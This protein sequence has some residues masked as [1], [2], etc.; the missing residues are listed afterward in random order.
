ML[1]DTQSV[2]L[3]CEV[4]PEESRILRGS[5]RPIVLLNKHPQAT[6]AA[7]L[8]DGLT[9]LGV[10]L[11]YTPVQMLLLHD[12][13][14]AWDARSGA[15]KF[16]KNPPMLVMTSGNIHDEPIVIDDKIAL[17]K[18]GEIAD[19]ILGNNREILTRF[20]DSV[21]RV[22]SVD[23]NTKAVQTIRRA[24]GF[25]PRPLEL[26]GVSS[27]HA[28]LATGPEQK[29]TFTLLNGKNA[30]VSQHI[31]D[32]EN[33]ETFD[34]WLETKARFEQLFA[35]KPTVLACDMHPEYITSKWAHTQSEKQ[36]LPLVEVQ[37]HHAHIVSAMAE[38]NLSDAV[39]GIA[40]DGTGYGV[41]G[42][43]WGGEVLLA[44]RQAF[45]R[46]ANFA[47]IP[48]PGGA[49]CVKHPLRMAYGALWA[50]D[51][52]EHPGAAGVIEALG[53]QQ[54]QVC[55]AMIEQGL[56][57][58]QTSSVG[59]LFD[60]ASA[61]LGVCTEPTYEGEGACKLGALAWEQ[62]ASTGKHACG[63]VECPSTNAGNVDNNAESGASANTNNSA[64]ADTASRYAIQVVKNTAT[65][66]ST[67]QDTS[68]LL[69]DAQPTFKAILDD[70]CAGKS[71]A[72]IALAFHEAIVGA[73]VQAAE[74][75]RALYGL[76]TVVL[77]GGVFMNRLIVERSVF[78]LE[79]RGFTVALNRELPPNDGCISLGQAVIACEKL[80]AAND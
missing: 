79:S 47:Y 71:A 7:G 64:P 66:T 77:S 25:A 21:V 15:G 53:A 37:H 65:A 22:I 58:P 69:F 49:A 23:E 40:F 4:S 36:E 51:L 9:E 57:T 38:N 43:I 29:N 24:R 68:V 44:N 63:S 35:V 28:I 17:G 72:E 19:G 62:Y 80:S 50:F 74:L 78:E 61:I 27:K 56:N 34:A 20:D 31:G 59:R 33:A 48:M 16:V 55:E 42:A 67:A 1:K 18:L 76:E 30:Y 60:A 46:F 14:E 73:I 2:E 75:A 32:M 13:A 6:F 10:M 3:V 5:E 54:V 45:E 11:P 12:F 41:D 39:C 52:L 70:I 26:E 8:A